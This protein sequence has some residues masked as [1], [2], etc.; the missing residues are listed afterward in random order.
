M[1]WLPRNSEFEM[2]YRMRTI[3]LSNSSKLTYYRTG[4]HLSQSRNRL[5]ISNHGKNRAIK[6]ESR[7]NWPSLQKLRLKL[8][9]IQLCNDDGTSSLDKK[10]FLADFVVSTKVFYISIFIRKWR[11]HRIPPGELSQGENPCQT[12]L[13]DYKVK[14]SQKRLRLGYE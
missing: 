6:P 11:F 3:P 7:R 9:I 13:S 14:V 8:V 10:V 12:I 4:L 5:P 1:E 2:A